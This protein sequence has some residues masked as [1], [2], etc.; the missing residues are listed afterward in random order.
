MT[1]IQGT[2][3]K[4]KTIMVKTIEEAYQSHLFAPVFKTNRSA[5]NSLAARGA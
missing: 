1:T 3:H 4:G 5:L 2:I